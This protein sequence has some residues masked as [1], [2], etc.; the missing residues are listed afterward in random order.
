MTTT[1]AAPTATVAE[2]LAAL[3]RDGYCIAQ[4]LLPPDRLA[5]VREAFDPLVASTPG[6]RNSFEGYRTRR[7]YAPFAKTR[8]LDQLALD[9]LVLGVLDELLGQYQLSQP[10]AISI[11]PG[12]K[13]QAYHTDDQVYPLPRP[14]AEVVANV[15]WAIDDFTEENGATHVVPGSHRWTDRR[16]TEDEPCARAVMPAG[17]AL[18]WVGSLYHCGGENQSD[19]P[20]LGVAMEYCASWLRPQENH[21]LSIPRAV[22]RDLPER[23]QELLG[24]NVHGILG[25]VDGRHP[26]KYL[27]ED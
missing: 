19:R 11:G 27:A 23:L 18:I 1:L 10:V 4:G 26:K 12:E 24:Y 13:R 16:P 20:R 2:A 22:V 25:N 15:M 3:D 9:P 14:H 21:Y 5:A 6:G 17:S 8:V 7:V